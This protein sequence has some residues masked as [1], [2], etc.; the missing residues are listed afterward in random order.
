MTQL[1]YSTMSDKELRA[2][3]LQHRED[4]EAMQAYFKRVEARPHEVVTAVGDPDFDTKIEAA[5]RRQIQAANNTT[6]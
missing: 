5:V 6:T 3:F 1:N 4:K 2:Y